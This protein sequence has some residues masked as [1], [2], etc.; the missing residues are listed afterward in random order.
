MRFLHEKR[1]MD[2]SGY[3]TRDS[4]ERFTAGDGDMLTGS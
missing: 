1:E 4:P 3:C 2:V